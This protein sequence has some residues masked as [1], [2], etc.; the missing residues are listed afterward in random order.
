GFS[1][2]GHLAASVSTMFDA[3][4]L[5]EA[6]YTPDAIDAVSAKPDFSI[7]IYPVIDMTDDKVTHSGSRVALTQNKKDLYEKLSPQLHVTK[8]TPPAFLA[9]GSN[10]RVV[11]V[12][13]SLLY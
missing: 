11:P 5:P 13:N 10:D 7:L 2:G 3:G 8:D 9:A 6:P 4:L 12:A 1:A